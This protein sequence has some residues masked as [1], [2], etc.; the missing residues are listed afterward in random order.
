MTTSDD[1]FRNDMSFVQ[2]SKHSTPIKHGSP[3]LVTTG[4]DSAMPYLASDMF[5]FKA[6]NNGKVIEITPE[7]MLV[8]YTDKTKDYIN[9]DEQT[10][11]NSDGGFYITLQ[12]I[13]DLKVG[14]KFKSGDVI[15][16]DKA[17]FSKKIGLQQLSYNVG[18]LAKIAILTSEDGYEDSGVC[19]EWLSHAME[20]DVVNLSSRALKPNSDILFIVNKGDAVREGDPILIYQNAFDDDDANML[21]KNLNIEDDD[22][23]TVGKTVMN[24]K[25][26]G[27]ISDIKLYRTCDIQD[28]SESLQK[29]FKAKEAKISKLKK[30][31]KDS[32]NPAQFDPDTKLEAT[33]KMK[34]IDDGV[35]I[36][37]YMRYNDKLAI[38][39]KLANLN[40]NKVVLMDVYPD[41]EAPYT[42]Y[43]PD[44]KIDIISSAASIDARMIT[45]PFKNGALNKLLIEL[46][47]KCAEIYGKKPMNMHEIYDYY[48]K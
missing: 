18:C 24:S 5:A 9:L 26:T 19:S 37:I 31:S 8:E 7:Y 35:L 17:S 13:T 44:D 43:R 6:K 45:S 48:N 3:L 34:A 14:S 25:V 29:L 47:R 1:S 22:I 30:I 15:A 21:L 38:G 4:A 16:W 23:S 11:K 41:E 33:G 12:L 20:S 2:T 42:D 39:D 28:M 46:Q 10:M 40:A 27:V 36:E 32:L